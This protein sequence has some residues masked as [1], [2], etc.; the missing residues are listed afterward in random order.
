[1]FLT[2]DIRAQLLLC[3]LPLQEGVDTCQV[4]CPDVRQQ[5]GIDA[6][7]VAH[8]LPKT[9]LRVRATVHQECEPINC[10][11]GT[12]SAAGREHVA[13]GTG[14]LEETDGGRRGQQVKGGW[15]AKSTRDEGVEFPHGLHGRQHLW[16]IDVECTRTPQRLVSQEC[17]SPLANVGTAEGQTELGGGKA[18]LIYELKGETTFNRHRH[19]N[20][21]CVHSIL[22]PALLVFV[23]AGV[24]RIVLCETAGLH[25]PPHSDQ[26]RS[27]AY[28][29]IP[30]TGEQTPVRAREAVILF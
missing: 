6:V 25:F 8:Q 4:L 15:W 16:G 14:Q 19:S 21:L 9:G 13:A 18:L 20:D 2:F 22:L 26:P 23:S 5:N 10:K 3:H 30:S 11:E 24:V 27:A 17:L 7:K 28:E 12:V 29:P 1:M